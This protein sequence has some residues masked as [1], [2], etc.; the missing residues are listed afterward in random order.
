M[1]HSS[2]DPNLASTKADPKLGSIA[3]T[4]FS[5]FINHDAFPL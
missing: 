5:I 3:P 2:C 1:Q 4:F